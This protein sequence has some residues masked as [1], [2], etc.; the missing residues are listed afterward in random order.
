[1]RLIPEQ[2]KTRM[3]YEVQT[4]PTLPSLLAPALVAFTKLIIGQLAGGIV[5]RAQQLASAGA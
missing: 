2:G 4:F 5:K 1:V 3:V